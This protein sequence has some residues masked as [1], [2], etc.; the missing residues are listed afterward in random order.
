MGWRLFRSLG[1][2]RFFASRLSHIE[3]QQ[4]VQLD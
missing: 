2:Q 3:W 4:L 1:N